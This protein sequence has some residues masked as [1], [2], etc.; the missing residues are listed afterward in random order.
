M[1]S[2]SVMI[3]EK[4]TDVTVMNSAE[5]ALPKEKLTKKSVKSPTLPGL[6]EVF[7]TPTV[8]LLYGQISDALLPLVAG[9]T[10]NTVVKK[11][12]KKPSTKAIIPKKITKAPAKIPKKTAVKKASKPKKV[13]VKKPKVLAVKKTPAK[14]KTSKTSSDPVLK[15]PQNSQ[16][17][18]LSPIARAAAAGSLACIA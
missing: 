2:S 9:D 18:T 10:T 14:A 1:I 17:N 5:S 4:V 12:V 3:Y 13:T 15:N 7:I 16:E 8:E 11:S 6:A